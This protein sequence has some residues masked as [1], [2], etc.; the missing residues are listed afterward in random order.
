LGANG[1]DLRSLADVAVVVPTWNTQRIQE[2]QLF[3]LHLLCELLEMHLSP[4]Q[5][6]PALTMQQTTAENSM[7]APVFRK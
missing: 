4:A 6:E 7:H 1:G 2:V 3:I 5:V